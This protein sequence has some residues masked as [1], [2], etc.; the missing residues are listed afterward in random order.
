MSLKFFLCPLF[1]LRY[2]YYGMTIGSIFEFLYHLHHTCPIE[3][4]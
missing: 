1:V 4:K 3:M 2:Y